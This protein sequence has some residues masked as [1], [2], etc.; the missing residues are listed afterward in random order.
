M[1]ERGNSD[2]A[3]LDAANPLELVVIRGGSYLAEGPDEGRRGAEHY[4]FE[5]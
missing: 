3:L 1:L 5:G 2:A 4:S